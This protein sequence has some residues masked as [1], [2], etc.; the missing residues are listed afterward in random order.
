MEKGK[1]LQLLNELN[2]KGLI[3]DYLGYGETNAIIEKIITVPELTKQAEQITEQFWADARTKGL[4]MYSDAISPNNL[5]EQPEEEIYT[6][7]ITDQTIKEAPA[8]V[9]QYQNSKSLIK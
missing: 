3:K 5:K 7:Y 4:Y 8:I 1:I 9:Y 2:E 6:R